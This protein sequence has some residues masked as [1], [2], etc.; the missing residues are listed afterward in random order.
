MFKVQAI[1]ISEWLISYLNDINVIIYLP[2]FLKT[3]P[4]NRP[5]RQAVIFVACENI[6]FSSLFVVGDVSRQPRR[7]RRNGCFRRLL[8]SA[9][10]ANIE[11]MSATILS[12]SLF[13]SFSFP[14]KG[15][16]GAKNLPYAP[17]SLK[18]LKISPRSKKNLP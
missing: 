6:R 16:L 9:K 10:I 14:L 2:R 4:P 15:F 7:A 17:F 11:T 8:F 3:L 1:A 12:R 5:L 13:F 18:W